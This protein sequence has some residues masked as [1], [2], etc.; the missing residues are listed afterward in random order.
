MSDELRPLTVRLRPDEHDQIDSIRREQR[1]PP[2]KS[3][4][5]AQLLRLELSRRKADAHQGA[6]A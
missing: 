5:A 3:A 6:S 2:S 1:S 4:A